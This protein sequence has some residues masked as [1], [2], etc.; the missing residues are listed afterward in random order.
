MQIYIPA[1]RKEQIKLLVLFDELHER[2]KASRVLENCPNLSEMSNRT[3]PFIAQTQM[4]K[5]V[6]RPKKGGNVHTL[7]MDV[8]YQ[9]ILIV[10]K[11]SKLPSIH[12]PVVSANAQ[13]RH[14]LLVKRFIM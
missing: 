8:L 12:G 14:N 3:D 6:L 7:R 1:D 5:N 4:G 9:I 2:M 10:G 13:S 11:N